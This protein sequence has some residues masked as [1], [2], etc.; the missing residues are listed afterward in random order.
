MAVLGANGGV[1]ASPPADAA[2]GGGGATLT[3]GLA[4]ALEAED[5]LTAD[6]TNC[7]RTP[8]VTG[9]NMDTQPRPSSSLIKVCR[10][11]STGI[12]VSSAQPMIWEGKIK[13]QK[14]KD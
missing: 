1:G 12:G 13:Y 2:L 5:P 4:V 9:W 7:K 3:A 10:S 11:S 14:M 6:P 8:P